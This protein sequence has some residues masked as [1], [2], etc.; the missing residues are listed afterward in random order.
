M[1]AAGGAGVERS[2]KIRAKR[3]YRKFFWMDLGHGVGG[4]TAGPDG[5]GG[6][7]LRYSLFRLFTGFAN[8]AFMV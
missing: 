3:V 5:V 1:P 4:E 8:A 6:L 7:L 2:A